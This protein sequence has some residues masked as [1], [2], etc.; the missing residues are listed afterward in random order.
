MA[1]ENVDTFRRGVEAY[2]RRDVEALIADADPGIEWHPAIL[3]RLGGK[4]TVYRGHD[5]LR[6]L[7]IDTDDTVAEIHVEFPEVRDLGDRVLG[8]GRIRTRGRASGIVTEAPLGCLADF[9]DEKLTR[10]QTYLDPREALE[11]AG[12]SESRATH[13]LP[14]MRT[15]RWGTGRSRY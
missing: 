2:N 4:S 5:G 9:R 8:L 11:A 1:Q 15:P 7:L 3:V 14:Q 10:V 6:E 13:L 12:L